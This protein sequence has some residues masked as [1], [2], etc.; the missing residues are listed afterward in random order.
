M[1]VP[2]LER[3]SEGSR[4]LD[5]RIAVEVAGFR[6]IHGDGSLFDRGND[7]YWTIDGDEK[8]APLPH[9]TTSLDAGLTLVPEGWDRTVS[10]VG[11]KCTATIGPQNAPDHEPCGGATEALA[12]CIAAPKARNA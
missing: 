8:T 10:R 9:Y 7:G 5:V 2:A 11:G 1:I 6:D 3:A 12:L 4:E